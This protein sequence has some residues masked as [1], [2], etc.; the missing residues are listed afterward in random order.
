MQ[1]LKLCFGQAGVPLAVAVPGLLDR[2]ELSIFSRT[3]M[4]Y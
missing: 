2:I 3:G 4:P 1:R